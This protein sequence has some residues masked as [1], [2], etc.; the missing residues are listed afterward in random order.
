MGLMTGVQRATGIV[1]AMSPTTHPRLA[2]AP[3]GTTLA[4]AVAVAV[5]AAA[6]AS[7]PST[8]FPS[9]APSPVSSDAYRRNYAGYALLLLGCG[10]SCPAMP[11]TRR[12]SCSGT[13]RWRRTYYCES[14]RNTEIRGGSC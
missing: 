13:R 8:S 7:P 11:C 9:S 2:A 5:A 10:A 1:W 3:Y 6:A 14:L 12:P 4:V